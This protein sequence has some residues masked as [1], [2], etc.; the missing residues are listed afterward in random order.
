MKEKE[1][2]SLYRELHSD[3]R[4]VEGMKSCINCG[5]CTAICPGAEFYDYDPRML[6]NK[7]Q[8]NDESELEELLKS[9]TI[10]FC[11]ECMSCKTRCPRGNT[12]GLVIMALRNLA[13]DRGY[14][15]ESEKGRQ[16]LFLKRVVGGWILNHGYCLY[17]EGIGTDLYPEQGPVWDWRQEN[18]GE[19][20]ERLGANYKGKGPGILRKIP[21]EALEE[22]KKI[23]DVT[24]GTERFE[25]IEE[26]SKEKS[27]EMGIELTDEL[28]N[29]YIKHIYI[30]TENQNK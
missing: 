1:T 26:F 8:K 17:L 5:T 11:G 18:W 6:M 23:F 4:Y 13:M 2:P 3:L 24:G 15:V 30:C 28:M 27:E 20:M 19:V 22:I 29:D 25:K 12:P 9:D 7:I 14:F 10:W 16:Q 21:D